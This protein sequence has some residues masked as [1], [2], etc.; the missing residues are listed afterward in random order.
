MERV[1][2]LTPA[3]EIVRCCV[4]GCVGP[5][6]G[7]AFSKYEGPL[8][9]YLLRQCYRCGVDADGHLTAGDG[10]MLGVCE[11]CA[12]ILMAMQKD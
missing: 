10:K 4:D 2:E 7:G 1:A 5:L 9:G 11:Q 8:K 6:I 12:K 3:G